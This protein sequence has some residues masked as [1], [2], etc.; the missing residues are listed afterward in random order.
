MDEELIGVITH[1]FGKAGVGVVKITKG[2]LEVGDKIKVKSKGGGGGDPS[3]GSGSRLRLEQ[4]VNSLQI[5][6][7]PVQK[8]KKGDEA[9]LKLN[10]AVREGDE[11]YKII[12]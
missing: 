6:R 4:E 7:E 3:T 9:G 8:I 10:E 1:Y 12:D 11:V 2:K 5:E